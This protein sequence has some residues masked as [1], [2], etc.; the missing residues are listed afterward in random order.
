M[1]EINHARRS[2]DILKEIAQHKPDGKITYHDILQ[3]LGY[4]AFGL[5]LLFFA[6]PS[7]LPFS[8]IPGVSF[9]F[10]IP[11]AIFAF[12]MIIAQKALWLPKFIG[13]R[14]IPY[15]K[16][17]KIIHKVSPFLIKIEHLLKPRLYFMTKGFMK[18]MSGVVLF[19][20]AIFLTLPIPFSNF[21]F[22]LLIIV[23]SLGLIEKDG[24]FIILGYI[25]TA[26]YIS[27][28]YVFIFGAIKA[29][30]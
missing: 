25:G 13:E 24:L 22:A 21:L 28:M 2:S 1:E 6:L 16:V 4:R 12:Q 27:F 7:A 20:L 14:T 11:I 17:S 15:E 18:I 8:A 29:L 5:V 26:F 3:K 30:F 10:S 23:I 9:I 19:C